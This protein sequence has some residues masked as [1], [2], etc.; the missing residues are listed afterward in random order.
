[1]PVFY[2][3]NVTIHVLA[4]MV[5]LGGMFFVA[6]VG[7]PMLR[8]IEVPAV[9]QQVFQQ[10]GIRFRAV[11]WWSIGILVVTGIVN[12]HYR[13]W[14]HW[15]GVFAS[16][17]FWTSAVGYSLAIK[18]GA[19]TAMIIV[20]AIHDFWIGPMAGR[21]TP[22]SPQAIAIRH[23]AAMLARVNALLGLIVVIVAVQLAR[24][25]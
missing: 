25:V 9:R 18:L 11:G 7:A 24:G 23:W 16:R 20:S 17:A 5:W 8:A 1:M 6:V 10:L 15:D 19:V 4:A 13:G 12:L 3:V 2:Y 21:A 22:G 14:L